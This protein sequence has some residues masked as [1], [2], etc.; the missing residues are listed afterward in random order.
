MIV[1]TP[2]NTLQKVVFEND[3]SVFEVS[4]A[5]G[6]VKHVFFLKCW[7]LY[8]FV[9]FTSLLRMRFKVSAFVN[10]FIR[11]LLLWLARC[12]FRFVVD[13]LHFSLLLIDR[14]FIILCCVMIH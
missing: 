9:T 5:N 12:D 13:V 8:I 11:F 2:W 14:G 1:R 7:S 10:V 6:K 4:M 3:T